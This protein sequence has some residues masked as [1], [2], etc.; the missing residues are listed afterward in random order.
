MLAIHYRPSP[1]KSSLQ[2]TGRCLSPIPEDKQDLAHDNENSSTTYHLLINQE[3]KLRGL[4]ALYRSEYLDLLA[5][6]QANRM[7]AERNVI[8][9]VQTIEQLHQFLGTNR[10]GENIQRGNSVIVMHDQTMLLHEINRNNIL[11]DL[12]SECGVGVAT[13]LDGQL[14]VCQMF[15]GPNQPQ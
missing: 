9:S 8:H 5:R 1:L 14:Y 4:P 11:S 12:F 2:A 15:R 3:R 10:A 6:N 13:G 7:A